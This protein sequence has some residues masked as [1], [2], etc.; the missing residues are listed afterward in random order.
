M[1][2]YNNLSKILKMLYKSNYILWKI[3]LIFHILIIPISCLT[4]DRIELS[5]MSAVGG[6]GIPLK[7]GA[8]HWSV[9]LNLNLH[10]PYNIISTRIATNQDLQKLTYLGKKQIQIDEKNI[11]AEQYM[12]CVYFETYKL[13]IPNFIF[14]V[15]DK[16]EIDSP[17]L[18]LSYLVDKGS[19]IK[20]LKDNNIIDTFQFSIDNSGPFG[21]ILFG[22]LDSQ[23]VAHKKKGECK[24][25]KES[26]GCYLRQI[27]VKNTTIFSKKTY[28]L[29][30]TNSSLIYVPKQVF[31]KIGEIVF[32]DYIEKKDCT[33][34]E[35]Y[36]NDSFYR[37]YCSNLN[38]FP[39]FYFY[40]GDYVYTVEFYN[41]F[42]EYDGFCTFLIERNKNNNPNEIIIGTSFISKFES[43]FNYENK[44]VS[45]L[46]KYN[47]DIKFSKSNEF[48]LLTKQMIYIALIALLAFTSI[49]N[50]IPIIG[51]S[52]NK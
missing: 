51:S 14:Y 22:S 41:L 38:D 45:F 2:I 23:S 27:E 31:E 28:A 19:L 49:L 20:L 34:T 39:N 6:Q 43:I 9:Y 10:M 1:I 48:E 24:V 44:T 40:I 35:T 18:S 52:N 33:Y 8:S 26:W 47:D 5:I 36:T 15:V 3:L 21:T 13:T 42:W 4:G 12:D 29:F 7:I 30:N 11:E 16:E 32:K 17:Q 25:E 37:C 46:S 50:I